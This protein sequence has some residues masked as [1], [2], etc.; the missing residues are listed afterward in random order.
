MVDVITNSSS[1]LFVCDT[2]KSEEMIREMLKELLDLYNK[3]S[4]SNL[5]FD[6]VFDYPYAVKDLEQ[7]D[8]ILTDYYGKGERSHYSPFNDNII[9][10]RSYDDNSIP[11]PL[12]DWIEEIFNA[13][14][15]HLG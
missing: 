14:R 11:G 1:E 13:E 12:Q 6:E 2:T 4:D 7:V 3:Q 8:L 5:L 10:I 15:F 9:I